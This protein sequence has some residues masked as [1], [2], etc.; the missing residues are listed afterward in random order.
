MLP[1]STAPPNGC[2]PHGRRAAPSAAADN[3]RII[4]EGVVALAAKVDRLPH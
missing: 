2:G 4:A 3:I 1:S